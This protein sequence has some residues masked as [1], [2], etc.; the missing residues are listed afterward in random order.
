MQTQYNANPELQAAAA[1]LQLTDVFA[2]LF[3]INAELSNLW[4]ER[5]LDEVEKS[6]PSPSSLRNDL[7]TSYHDFCEIV[8]QTVK[9]QPNPE[10]ETLFSLINEIRIKYSKFLP[11]KLTDANTMVAPIEIQKYTGKHITPVPT[12]SIK[13]EDGE[14]SELLF[15]V[16][17]YIT[18]KNNVE[19]GEAQI[20]I[21]G[22][23]KYIGNYKSTFHIER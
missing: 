5:A 1:T 15:T 19:I 14:F 23:G 3:T 16:D 12:V 2:N 13:N 8:L 20:M 18:Y 4:K 7:E 6:G 10:V 9:Y 22:K 11:I 21:H 17:F